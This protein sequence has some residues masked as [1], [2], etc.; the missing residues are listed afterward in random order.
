M[1]KQAIWRTVAI[2]LS[3]VLIG[4]GTVAAA[5][6]V[7]TQENPMV[8]L[9]YLTE[10]FL[11]QIMGEVNTEIE[12]R[13]EELN[14]EFDVKIANGA[15]GGGTAAA[16]NFSVVTLKKGQTLKGTLGAEV[17][18]RVGSAVCVADSAPG[19]IDSTTAGSIDS[20]ANLEK[21]HLYL[22]TIVNRGVKATADTVKVLVRGGYTVE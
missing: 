18:L 5:G 1:K 16:S 19:M 9:S 22:M 3:C 10:K 6:S 21:N 20:G 7:G 2:V 17:M 13:N 12:A 8:T 4:I 15:S 11:P 14:R